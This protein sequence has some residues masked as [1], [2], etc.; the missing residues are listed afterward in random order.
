MPPGE[1]AAIIFDM[2]LGMPDPR[3]P[4]LLVLSSVCAIEP[5]AQGATPAAEPP[6]ILKQPVSQIGKRLGSVTFVVTASGTPPLTYQ[7]F[8]DSKSWS[9]WNRNSLTLVGLTENDVGIY[10]VTVSNAA[11][12]VTSEGVRLTLAGSPAAVSKPEAPA[13]VTKPSPPPPTVPAD[14]GPRPPEKVTIEYAEVGQSITWAATADGPAPLRFQWKKDDQPVAGATNALFTIQ[15]IAEADAG[16][17]LCV[18][19]NS[20]GATASAPIKLVVRKP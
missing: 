17:Y 16:I 19:R 2:K 6:S 12:S 13:P 14:S 7:W 20:A 3:V 5:A 8:R 15:K 4:I 10:T 1:A 9:E 18:V 11:G